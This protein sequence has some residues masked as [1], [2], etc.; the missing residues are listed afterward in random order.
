MKLWST[1]ALGNGKLQDVKN[2]KDNK[3][4]TQG[5]KYQ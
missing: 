3:K 4:K 1:M 2:L 5:K